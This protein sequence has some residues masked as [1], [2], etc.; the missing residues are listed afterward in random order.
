MYGLD[1][2]PSYTYSSIVCSSAPETK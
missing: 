2:Y 1:F